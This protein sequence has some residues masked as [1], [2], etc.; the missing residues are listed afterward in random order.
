MPS[1]ICP[2]P[3]CGISP[4]PMRERKAFGPWRPSRTPSSNWRK[5]TQ[6]DFAQ[7]YVDQCMSKSFNAGALTGSGRGQGQAGQQRTA[8]RG[9]G[10]G[11]ARLHGGHGYM[12]NTR[13]AGSIP[14]AKI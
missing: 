6:L 1:V 14:D 13:S 7:V 10:P 11:R 12:T 9:G 3:S 4:R 8:G 2:R 5:C